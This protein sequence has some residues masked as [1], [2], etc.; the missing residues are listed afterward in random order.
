MKRTIIAILLFLAVQL[1]ATMA[2]EVIWG[3]IAVHQSAGEVTFQTFVQE[4]FVQITA[5]GLLA[6]QILTF[7]ILRALN[8]CRLSDMKRT[9]SWS[10][11]AASI[12]LSFSALF[13][14][15]IINS[16]LNLPNTLEEQ[17]KQLAGSWVAIVAIALTGPVIE[18]FVFR[19]VIIDELYETFNHR[20]WPA[21][22]ISSLLFGIIHM[23][24]AQMLFAMLAGIV[25]GWIYC[26]T[27]SVLPG[28][29]GHVINNA[30]GVIDMRTEMLSGMFEEPVE[31][32]RDPVVTI[33]FAGLA[34]LAIVCVRYLNLHDRAG[35]PVK[36][37]GIGNQD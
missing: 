11:L 2:I 31:L 28:I 20:K 17:F 25:F 3:V 33:V 21:I 18:E 34:V 14:F 12:V 7:I 24:P 13:D 36:G 37:S 27:G 26:K 6:S 35:H 10:I 23:N 4:H 29:I 19:K 9:I 22:L 5:L 1:V 30:I 16:S 15:D 32:F 8:Y